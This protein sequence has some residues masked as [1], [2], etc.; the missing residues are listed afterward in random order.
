MVSCGTQLDHRSAR[1][2]SEHDAITTNW[3]MHGQG[4]LGAQ[5]PTLQI[6]SE[7]IATLS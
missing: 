5:P 6:S 4:L 7:T 1:A 3:P 2:A